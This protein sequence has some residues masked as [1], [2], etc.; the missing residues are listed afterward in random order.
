MAHIHVKIDNDLKKRFKLAVLTNGK[1]EKK[2]IT[3]MINAYLK[4]VSK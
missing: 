3:E 4:K 1:T 2:I